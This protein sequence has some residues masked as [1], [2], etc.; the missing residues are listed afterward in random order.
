MPTTKSDK[1]KYAAGTSISIAKSRADIERFLARHKAT[2]F[3]YGEQGG[4][5]MIAFELEG[6]RYRMDLRYPPLSSFENLGTNQYTARMS[7]QERMVA[8]Q[9]KEKL[10]L[11]RGLVLLVKAKLEAV[12]SGI[13]T[14]E[15]ELL[16]YTI[17]PNNQ[18]VGE[19]LEPQLKE[20][21]RTGKMP[22]LIPGLVTDRQKLIDTSNIIEGKVIE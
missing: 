7:Q 6:R 17:M 13:T 8:A 11:W 9:E 1:G 4:V 21:Y 3:M 22:P 12:S 5:A 19:W 10:R 16:S 2:G 18:T 20:V 14:L 15:E